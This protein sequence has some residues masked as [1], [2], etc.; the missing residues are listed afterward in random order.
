MTAVSAYN[1][2]DYFKAHLNGGVASGDAPIDFL[3]DT[4][5]VALVLSAGAPSLTTHDFWSDLSASELGSGNGYTTG[6][7]TL[8]SKTVSTPS[9]GVVTVDCANVVWTFTAT[10]TFR[11]GVVYKD[12]G[13]GATSPLM[14]LIDFFGADVGITAG[15]FTWTLDAAGLYTLT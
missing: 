10:K 7:E 3:T 8:A 15:T 14:M 1:E 2:F 13:S 11:Y 9:G 6:G 12:T 4:I 5:K